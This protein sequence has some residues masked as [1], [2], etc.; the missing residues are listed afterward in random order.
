[1]WEAF[2]L[3]KE[4]PNMSGILDMQVYL[5]GDLKSVTINFSYSNSVIGEIYIR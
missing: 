2:E 4:M 5:D 1:M 3:L